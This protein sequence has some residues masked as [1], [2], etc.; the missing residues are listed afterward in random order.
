[1]LPLILL[2]DDE[3]EILDFLER[4][5]NNKYDILKAENAKDALEILDKEAVQL[6][7]ADVMMP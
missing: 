7:I 2:V 3:E 5:L 4:I 6:I 1:M